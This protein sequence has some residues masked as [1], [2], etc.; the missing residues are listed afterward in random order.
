MRDVN[1]SDQTDIVVSYRDTQV[2]FLFAGSVEAKLRTNR[3]YE[4]EMLEYIEALDLP[5]TYVD[6]GGYVGTH[7]L[8]FATYCNADHVHTFE[9][10]PTAHQHILANIAANTLGERVTAHCIGLSDREESLEV[11]FEGS[12]EPAT[13]Q[14]L[15][16]LIHTPVAVM[17][18]DVE[19]MEPKVLAGATRILAED[20]PVLFIEAHT[21]DELRTDLEL[22]APFGYQLTGRVF[23]AT[24]TYE[25]AAPT[26][27]RAG[28]QRWPTPRSLIARD[29]WHAE[30][31]LEL[32]WTPAGKLQLRSQL[33]AG[34][35]TYAT[36][37]PL[38]LRVRPTTTI[39]DVPRTPSFLQFAGEVDGLAYVYVMAYDDRQRT[40]IE[41]YQIRPRVL[42][43]LVI[44]EGTR[45]LRFMIR[46]DGPC[47]VTIDD[48]FLLEMRG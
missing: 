8:F 39:V 37:L 36:Q 13:C 26:S 12:T 19:G 25:F 27:P 48:L 28:A 5:G 46:L 42:G 10:R 34:A 18:I 9:P 40:A 2:R 31:Q 20:K 1:A 11:S 33:A 44:P 22:L 32:A 30:P 4:N 35:H 41:R 38:N 6:V 43:R 29:H 47:E 15:D 7:A 21:A 3:F 14:R 23:N 45:H 24:A 17:K 16:Q